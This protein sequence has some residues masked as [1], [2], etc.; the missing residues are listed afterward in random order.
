M[1]FYVSCLSKNQIIGTV[2]IDHVDN[3]NTI[4]N[5]QLLPHKIVNSTIGNI[6]Y[7]FIYFLALSEEIN[8]QV[9]DAPSFYQMVDQKVSSPFQSGKFC[10]PEFLSNGERI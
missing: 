8:H 10:F 4:Q 7:L 2:L 9:D 3:L 6:S 5:R 1:I